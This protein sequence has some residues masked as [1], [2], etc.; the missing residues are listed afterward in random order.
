MSDSD[1]E[2]GFSD[3]EDTASNG[4]IDS[5]R[6]SGAYGFGDESPTPI[7]LEN[8]AGSPIDEN[9]NPKNATLAAALAKAENIAPSD[10]VHPSQVNVDVSEA[11]HI[12]EWRV[13]E[14]AAREAEKAEE[15]VEDLKYVSPDRAK[16]KSTRNLKKRS[17]VEKRRGSAERLIATLEET[18]DNDPAVLLALADTGSP[19]KHFYPTE[20]GDDQPQVISAP[21]AGPSSAAPPAGVAA[22]TGEEASSDGRAEF[23]A[24]LTAFGGVDEPA[25]DEGGRD[26]PSSDVEN[27][28]P[29]EPKKRRL[30]IKGVKKAFARIGGGSGPKNEESPA[31]VP[32]SSA[33]KKRGSGL[34]RGGSTKSTKRASSSRRGSFFRRGSKSSARSVGSDDEEGGEEDASD[35]DLERDMAFFAELEA[36]RANRSK[37]EDD[38]RLKLIE[39]HKIQ[40]AAEEAEEAKV[41]AK[42][43]AQQAEEQAEEDVRREDLV[44]SAN[45]K[46]EEL[47]FNFSWG[48]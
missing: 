4:G 27:R 19:P 7:S 31:S 14:R 5:R 33:A 1:T 42:I 12:P 2:F 45:A 46:L 24:A 10:F 35:D 41:I 40:K 16:R 13:A 8:L 26:S 28:S 44:N 37:E 20:V 3:L 23:G 32:P 30:S 22:A 29:T 36:N 39:D 18:S 34:S 25:E 15:F 48:S 6:S 47:T 43:E 9:G 11:G 38:R 21:P 17:S